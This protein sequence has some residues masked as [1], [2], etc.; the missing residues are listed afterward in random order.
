[1]ETDIRSNNKL[2]NIG[3]LVLERGSDHKTPARVIEVIISHSFIYYRIHF[4]YHAV[5]KQVIL[6]GY[7]LIKYEKTADIQT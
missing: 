2:L 6:P 4:K 3:D 1:M 5:L 7:R